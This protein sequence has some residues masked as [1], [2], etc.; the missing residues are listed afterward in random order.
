MENTMLVTQKILLIDFKDTIQIGYF[1]L[2]IKDLG[3]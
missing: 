1:Q 2:R 3:E